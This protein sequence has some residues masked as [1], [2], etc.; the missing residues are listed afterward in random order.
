[1]KLVGIKSLECNFNPAK[2]T[3]NPHMHLIV[4]N[5]QMAEIIISESLIICG[6]KFAVRDAQNMQPVTNT[7]KALVET[8]KYRS[9]IFTEPDAISKARK[10]KDA[11]VMQQH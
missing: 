10:K 1:M 8:V 4:A 6:S 2:R 9:K 3:Y 7:E 5:K 11:I